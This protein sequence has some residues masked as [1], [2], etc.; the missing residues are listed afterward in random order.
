MM[1]LIHLS[2]VGGT[3]CLH[4]LEEMSRSKGWHRPP[5]PGA[6]SQARGKVPTTTAHG[7][8][9]AVRQVVQ[10]EVSDPT[11]QVAELRVVAIDSTRVLVPDHPDA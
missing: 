4:V 10:P 7:L 9:Q 3:S 6:L 2:A 5:T 11:S 8:W 1:A